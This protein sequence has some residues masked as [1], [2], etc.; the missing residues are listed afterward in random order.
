MGCRI[1]RASQTRTKCKGPYRASVSGQKHN[2]NTHRRNLGLKPS[3]L[4]G[5]AGLL[6]LKVSTLS[7]RAS[8]ADPSGSSETRRR[9]RKRSNSRKGVRRGGSVS[10]RQQMATFSAFTTFS[11]TLLLWGFCS[12][13]HAGKILVYPVDGS[14]WL[15]MNVLLQ[16]L[17]QRGHTMTVIRSSTSWYVSDQA[18]HYTSIT[19][20]RLERSSL[21]DP[22][23]MASFLKRNLEIS[24]KG[25][26]SVLA[27]IALQKEMVSMLSEAHQASAEMVRETPRKQEYFVPENLLMVKSL[28]AFFSG[29]P[30]CW[31][32]QIRAGAGVTAQQARFANPLFHTFQLKG[33]KTT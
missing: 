10:N 24:Q 13:S 11:L 28:P 20:P 1:G 3:L 27:F 12:E 32:D 22:E 19:I 5:E 4:N 29:A 9:R 18:P 14:H 21:E 26:G 23:Y 2:Y 30:R 8:E 17:H 33:K 15:N 16:E 25:K 31:L 6:L 7:H